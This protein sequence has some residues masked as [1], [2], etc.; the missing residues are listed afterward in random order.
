MPIAAAADGG[1]APPH[2]VEQGAGAFVEMVDQRALLRVLGDRT[3]LWLQD[4]YRS[5]VGKFGWVIPI[6]RVPDVSC[7]MEPALEGLDHE[8]APIFFERHWICGYG[9]CGLFGCAD[10][11]TG[12]RAGGSTA[13]VDDDAVEVWETG[14]NECLDWAVIS[15]TDGQAVADWVEARGFTMPERAVEVIASYL[16]RGWVFLVT[17]IH[18]VEAVTRPEANVTVRIGWERRAGDPVVYPL[19]FTGA[20]VNA[21]I[22]LRLYVAADKPMAPLN[23]AWALVPHETRIPN[24]PES[25]GEALEWIQSGNAPLQATLALEYSAPLAPRFGLDPDCHYQGWET[26]NDCHASDFPRPGWLDELWFADGPFSELLPSSTITRLTGRMSPWQMAEDVILVPVYLGRVMPT[27]EY[28]HPCVDRGDYH[29]GAAA[30]GLPPQA[31]LRFALALA[32][33]LLL[34]WRR[35]MRAAGILAA[36]I[37]AVGCWNVFH[38][39]PD[40]APPAPGREF[41][42]GVDND[43]N[44]LTDEWWPG[45]GQQ[46]VQGGGA[47]ATV[48][49]WACNMQRTGVYCRGEKGQPSAEVCNGVDDDCDGICDNGFA[50]CNGH[51]FP[52]QTACGHLGTALCVDCEPGICDI[53]DEDVFAETPISRQQLTFIHEFERDGEAPAEYLMVVPATGG[54]KLVVLFADGDEEEHQIDDAVGAEQPWIV[55][56]DGDGVD[57]V[58]VFSTFDGGAEGQGRV[59]TAYVFA[60]EGIEPLWRIASPEVADQL[61]DAVVAPAELRW[62]IPARG[63]GGETILLAAAE[64]EDGWYAWSVTAVGPEE[65]REFAQIPDCNLDD[66]FRVVVASFDQEP[67]DDL[68]VRCSG[69]D[70]HFLPGS[71]FAGLWEAG[72]A[73]E[74]GSGVL[75][76][77]DTDGDGRAKLVAFDTGDGWSGGVLR[78]WRLPGFDLVAEIPVH[79]SY[80]L[81]TLLLADDLDGDGADELV[82]SMYGADAAEGYHGVLGVAT[83]PDLLGESPGLGPLRRLYSERPIETRLLLTADFDGRPG[84]DLL[85]VLQISSGHDRV[86]WAISPAG[87]FADTDGRGLRR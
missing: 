83:S 87:C 38:D 59:V 76:P 50:C 24:T 12:S 82:F 41:C 67:G 32:V 40:D 7:S 77:A 10:G 66:D 84:R 49:V 39:G 8:T 63:P 81:N 71:A 20:T 65:P 55:D 35:R 58:L 52:C 28:D 11:A 70:A 15:S 16:S 74:I 9:G 17:E 33:L 68:L 86:E 14:G 62:M 22:N 5:N 80:G 42:D 2:V 31:L 23:Y 21:P 46:C 53:G 34:A 61:P 78:A 47:C 3:E 19:A 6:P 4:R 45:L 75:L 72:P 36:G 48:G 25:Y 27:Y 30:V 56:L 60:G 85:H 57:E 43:M 64:N 29:G 18:P 54:A 44:G 73:A 69:G 37:L 13:R 26:E 79:S 1:Y 51:F